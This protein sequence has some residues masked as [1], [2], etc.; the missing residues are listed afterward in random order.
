MD[1]SA[2]SL[3]TKQVWKFSG[4][5][6]I[7]KSRGNQGLQKIYILDLQN[8]RYK[9]IAQNRGLNQSENHSIFFYRNL[10]I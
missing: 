5:K 7:Y 1:L 10:E 8:K 3:C 2:P 6:K 4:S 9:L